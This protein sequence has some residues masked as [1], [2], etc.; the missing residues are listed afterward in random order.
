[1]RKIYIVG[2]IDETSYLAFS[3]H[4]DKLI[5]ESAT[6]PVE[7]ELVSGGGIYYDGLAFYGKIRSCP[8]PV[9]IT[10]HG[11]CHSAAT[12]V[13]AA[14][15]IRKATPETSFMVHN[16][17]ERHK[18]ELPQLTKK[19]EDL[20]VQEEHWNNLL[21]ERTLMKASFW[22]ALSNKETFFYA[23]DAFQ[24]GLI[25]QITKGEKHDSNDYNSR[26]TN[27]VGRKRQSS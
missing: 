18:G 19:L 13:L 1:M 22:S 14:G 26:D 9:H 17:T 3:K 27:I 21:A 23:D 4:L 7:I 24:Y 5:A 8:A 2:S 15:N 11:I 12:L 20:K 10:A 6:K 25:D 16:S